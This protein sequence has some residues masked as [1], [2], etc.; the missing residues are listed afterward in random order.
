MK[1]ITFESLKPEHAAIAAHLRK[2]DLDEINLLSRLSPD[3]AVAYSIAASEK[4]YA[5]FCNGELCAI[6]GVSGGVIWLVGTDTISK[7][8]I[9][10]YRI[11]RLCFKNLCK[12][13][14]RLENF[15]DARNFLSL[16]WLKW[17]GFKIEPAQQI[18]NGMFHYVHWEVEN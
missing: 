4:G 3:I 15:V 10:F 9:A 6:F 7:H 2:A 17:L 8:P 14:S 13:Y 5:V 12:G 16:R 11:S 1:G 18:N